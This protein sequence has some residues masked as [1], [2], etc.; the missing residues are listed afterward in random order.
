MRLIPYDNPDLLAFVNKILAE[1]RDDTNRLVFADWLCDGD[2]PRG[3]LL[4]VVPNVLEAAGPRSRPPKV[5]RVTRRN[6]RDETTVSYGPVKAGW[7]APYPIES[8]IPDITVPKLATR[9]ASAGP[10][11]LMSI[12]LVRDFMKPY[13]SGF[14]HY[15]TVL[16]VLELFACGVITAHYRDFVLYTVYES[17]NNDAFDITLHRYGRYWSPPRRAP[18]AS[19]WLIPDPR[20]ALKNLTGLLFHCRYGRFGTYVLT[21]H[22]IEYESLDLRLRLRDLQLTRWHFRTRSI[23][24]RDAWAAMEP[25]EDSKRVYGLNESAKHD[26]PPRSDSHKRYLLHIGKIPVCDHKGT[27]GR[28]AYAAHRDIRDLAGKRE[29]TVKCFLCGHECK[30]TPPS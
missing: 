17:R 9:R 22:H 8:R 20:S 26:R 16:A 30:R 28:T 2:D 14:R 25:W 10:G 15:D 13:G 5:E 4:R 12:A 3:P 1:P 27:D 23:K 11:R 7:V 24:M 21:A 19:R 29:R 18:D 6:Q